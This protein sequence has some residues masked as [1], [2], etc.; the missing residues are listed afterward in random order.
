MPVLCSKGD[1]ISLVCVVGIL[2]KIVRNKGSQC[3]DLEDVQ[4]REMHGEWLPLAAS[5]E[6]ERKPVLPPP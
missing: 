6:R 2:E 3:F 4:N 1:T 5:I